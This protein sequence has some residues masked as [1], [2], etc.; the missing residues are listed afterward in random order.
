[1]IAFI[2][3]HRRAY[4]VEPI[5]RELPIASSTY[6]AHAARFVRPFPRQRARCVPSMFDSSGVKVSCPT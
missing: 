6:H 1:M 5:C 2:D 3:D 4:G